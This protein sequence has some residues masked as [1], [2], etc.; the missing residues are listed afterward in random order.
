M[1][2][3]PTTEVNDTALVEID[4]E[5]VDPTKYRDIFKLPKTFEE[6]WNECPFQRKMWR[7]AITKEETKMTENKVIRLILQSMMEPGRECIKC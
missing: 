3:E 4:Y 5:K 6:A 7:D 1:D 2:V